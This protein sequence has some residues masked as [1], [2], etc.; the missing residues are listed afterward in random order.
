[1]VK[2]QE[3]ADFSGKKIFVGMDVHSKNWNNSIYYEGCLVRSFQQPP[4]TEVLAQLLKRDYPGA[5]Y[6]C[7]YEAGFC[8]LWI[9]RKLQEEGIN[10]IVVHAADVPQTDKGK[11]S[12]TDANDSKGIGRALQAGLLK[13]IY[14]PT[15]ATEGDRKMIRYRQ[16]VRRDL[17]RC[18]CRIKSLI[19]HTGIVLPQQFT[20]KNWS[21]AFI[22]WLKTVPVKY[23]PTRYTLD[24]LIAQE[25]ILRAEILMLNKELKKLLTTPRY[26]EDGQLLTAVPGIGTLAA[27]TLLVEIDNIKRFGC[28]AEFNSFIGLFPSEFSSGEK[29]H[30]GSIMPRHHKALRA[31]IMEAAWVAVRHDPALTLAFAALKKRMTAK[32]AI[33]KIARKLLN[34]IWHVWNKREAYEKGLV[35]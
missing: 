17:T 1:M 25:A 14:I 12:K 16:Q 27:I 10:C 23:H 2:L 9:Q 22:S 29:D 28:F 34:R 11:R 6:Y 26:K 7:A 31:L 13:G 8:G 32:R 30:K 15:E 35:A 18:R 3:R 19:H 24:R 5:E 20:V 4:K 21:L 33:T